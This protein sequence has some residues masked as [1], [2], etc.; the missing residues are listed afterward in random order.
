MCSYRDISDMGSKRVATVC[1]YL[2]FALSP[3]ATP[4][5]SSQT[6]VGREREIQAHAQKAQEALKSGNPGTADREFRAVLALDPNNTDAHGNLGVIRFFQADWAGAAEQFRRVLKVRPS[7]WKAQALLGICEKRLGHPDEAQRLLEQSAPHLEDSA[8]RIQAGL[9]LVEIPYRA[10]DLDKAVE[11]VDTLER[12]N[13][14]NVDVLY[15]VYRIHAD[16]ANRAR[17]ALALVAP[18]S[19][20]MHE[21]MAQHLVNEGDVSAAIAQYRKALAI[22]PRLGGIHYELGEAILKD[23]TSDTALRQAEEQFRAALAENPG[24]AGAE[25]RLGSVCAQRRDFKSAMQHYA[26]ALALR[27]DYVYAQI[28][29][30]EALM[31]MD[32]SQK[33][34]EH[35]LAA[36]RLDSLNPTVHYRL[37]SIYRKLGREPDASSEFEAF[38]KLRESKK[39]IEQVYQQM[40]EVVPEKEAIPPDTPKE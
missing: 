28:G 34:L 29:M 24:D 8:L 4:A 31:E 37:A 18:D 13:P 33:A 19:S 27:P 35:L 20:R 25:Y 12:A 23:S 36:S 30:G 7:L 40:H 3:F 9:E 6:D 10:G 5:R 1:F 11:I 26:R 2:A 17:D 16:L 32:Q 22:D 21:I 38:K 15:T 14:M 39:Q